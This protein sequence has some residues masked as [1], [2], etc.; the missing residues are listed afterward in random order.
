[1][2]TRALRPDEANDLLAA[3]AIDA[4]EEEERELV[5]QYVDRHPEAQAEVATLRRAAATLESR[6]GP[7]TQ[8][9]ERIRAE[10]DRDSTTTSPTTVATVIPFAAAQAKRVGRSRATSRLAKVMAIAAAVT[11]IAVTAVALTSGP[12]DPTQPVPQA[13]AQVRAAAQRALTAP[14]AQQGTVAS[15]DGLV[16]SRVVVLP[17]GVG[18]VLGIADK[19]TSHTTFRLVALTPDGPVQ[20]AVLDGPVPIAFQLPA[21]TLALSVTDQATPTISPADVGAGAG[22]TSTPS[23]AGAP[24]T[25]VP[26]IN[27]GSTPTLPTL[28]DGVLPVTLPHFP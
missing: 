20:V 5:A 18:Y 19:R 8:V 4:L 12:E 22:S 3:Y 25:S 24:T 1:M 11:G 13:S 17:S 6:Q 16:T 7:S 2:S 15:S 27:P 21:N 23:G 9:W 10:V 26:P 14:G 28:P